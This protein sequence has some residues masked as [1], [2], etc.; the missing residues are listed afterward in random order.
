MPYFFA[1]K[2]DAL[3]SRRRRSLEAE[4]GGTTAGQG[5][6]GGEAREAEQRSNYKMGVG[7]DPALNFHTTR[8]LP[9]LFDFNLCAQPYSGMVLGHSTGGVLPAHPPGASMCVALA[10]KR[11][12]PADDRR[13]SR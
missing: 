7:N 1:S 6:G 8:N 5:G 10:A 13:R 4:E 3:Y 12:R 9:S 2:S 11:V